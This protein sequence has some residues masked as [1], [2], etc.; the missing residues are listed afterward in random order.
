M[1]FYL[2]LF[3]SLYTTLSFGREVY[4]NHLSSESNLKSF[5]AISTWQDAKGG[6]WFGNNLLNR[7]DGEDIVNYRLSNYTSWKEDNNIKKICGDSSYVYILANRDIISYDLV[8]DDFTRLNLNANVIEL[9]NNKLLFGN[10]NILSLFDPI[11]CKHEPVVEF[12]QQ[13]IITSVL[14]ID[15]NN[16]LVATTTGVF[17]FNIKL[18]EI[19]TLSNVTKATSLF[20]DSKD[21]IWIGT[22]SDGVFIYDHDHQIEHLTKES[23]A[24]YNLSDNNIRCFEEVDGSVWVGTYNGITVVDMK[25]KKSSFLSAD[26][27][28]PH[29]LSH[30]SVYDIL[31]DKQGTIWVATYFGGISYT[32]SIT[33]QYRFYSMDVE[34]FSSRTNRNL[35]TQMAEDTEGNLYLATEGG[36]LAV[37]R[38]QTQGLMPILPVNELMP[39]HTVKSIWYDKQFNN[40]Y[41]GTFKDGLLV[42]DLSTNRVKRIADTILQTV[43]RSIIQTILP[44]QDYLIILTQDGLFKV[45]R[46]TYEGEPLFKDE[47]LLAITKEFMRYIYID[48]FDQLWLSTISNGLYSIQLKTNEFKHYTSEEYGNISV[49]AAAETP[50]GELYFTTA[51]AKFYA[52]NRTLNQFDQIND[53]NNISHNEVCKN[54]IFT[55]PHHLIATSD[56]AV[57]L[58][59]L[60]DFSETKKFVLDR[61]MPLQS[62]MSIRGLYE[63][64][65]DATIY[66]SGFQGVLAL[67]KVSIGLRNNQYNLY[68]TSLLVNNQHITHR[69]DSSILNRSITYLDTI[70]L[71]PNQNNI[72]VG[73]ASSDYSNSDHVLYEYKME[74]FDRSW[75][76][77]A[78]TKVTYSSLPPGS[79]KLKIREVDN[80]AKM[81]DV[82]ICVS[83]PIYATWYAYLFYLIVFIFILNRILNAYKRN[84]QL[85]NAYQLVQR[86]KLHIE[87]VNRG[88]L[89]FFTNISH[90]FRTPLTLIVAQLDLILQAQNITHLVSSRV[91]KVKMQAVNLQMLVTELL[92]FRKYEDGK[93]IVKRSNHDINQFLAD[94]FSSFKEYAAMKGIKYDFQHTNEQILVAFDPIQLQKVLYNLLSNA[95]K[96]TEELGS[97]SLLLSVKQNQVVICVKN[98]CDAVDEAH[99]ERIFDRY[100][101]I[102]A[103]SRQTILPGTGLGL[104]LSKELILA[105]GGDIKVFSEGSVIT[106]EITLSLDL[107]E[108]KTVE[109]DHVDSIPLPT[110]QFIL[111]E[112]HDE[113]IITE[114]ENNIIDSP[115]SILIVD[116]NIEIRA[117]LTEV[118][119]PMYIVYEAIDGVQGV[120][121]ATELMP[122]LILSDVMMQNMSGLE[123]SKELKLN[124]ETSHIPVVLISAQSSVAQAIEGLKSGAVDYV[125]KPFNIEELVLKCNNIVKN[126]NE[127][128]RKFCNT[129]SIGVNEIA[130]NRLDQAFLQ[131]SIDLIEANLS[132]PDF[133]MNVW[134]KELSIARSRLFSKVK[135]ITGLTPNDFVINIKLKKG[136]VL[137]VENKDMTVS[138]IAYRLGFAAPG[139]FGKCFKESFGVTPLQYRKKETEEH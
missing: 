121:M 115:Y 46:I 122:S 94:I 91:K 39:H 40:L 106:F 33:N 15:S 36:G 116:D 109:S 117:L 8:L 44:Y 22:S 135:E 19:T 136:A 30:K 79:Y 128:R 137:L 28:N 13:C 134:C 93:L 21:Q 80:P 64:P 1:K 111:N 107:I 124:I 43:E 126:I 78:Y 41:V 54:L 118:F 7:F 51:D 62:L 35:L 133:N 110:E 14:P 3:F 53:I 49:A 50:T 125:T 132:N 131:Q 77:T 20:I 56:F 82:H 45:D 95:F 87:E 114:D 127:V 63:S 24:P 12:P 99:L 52:F 108:T 57:T 103:T 101:Q 67:N 29:S 74:G 71:L 139:Y 96:F 92:D 66:V 90:E 5:S 55:L 48:S 120:K 18:D 58:I 85:K 38:N 17:N 61:S 27:S 119:S 32:Q 100:Y 11:Q 37:L 4:F 123:M 6:I 16:L 70:S 112:T 104:A 97:I 75:V 130:T 42:Y 102:E 73:F 76:E 138:E 26:F 81:I 129:P 60:E 113:K 31:K 2:A 98:T 65:S 89:Q 47:S 34:R 23:L 105:H 83:S 10:E 69:S 68:F 59:D 88:K 25:T 9:F 86:D 72:S 84:I